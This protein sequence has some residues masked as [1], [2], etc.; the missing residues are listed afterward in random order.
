MQKSNQIKSTLLSNNK[1]QQVLVAKIIVELQ[2][3]KC[4]ICLKNISGIIIEGYFD[5]YLPSDRN[6]MRELLFLFIER[7]VLLV[8]LIV[9]CVVIMHIIIIIIIIIVVIIISNPTI[10]F[11]VI[12]LSKPVWCSPFELDLLDA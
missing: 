1:V 12:N 2:L 5:H 7:L 8:C 4:A 9:K 10:M 11:V 6:K 3:L